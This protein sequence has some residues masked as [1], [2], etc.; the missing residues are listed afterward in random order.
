MCVKLMLPLFAGQ[1]ER[2]GVLQA[3]VAAA[4]LR[5]SPAPALRF[6]T[7]VDQTSKLPLTPSLVQASRANPHSYW[8]DGGGCVCGGRLM[9]RR[10]HRVKH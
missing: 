3:P 1:Q 10:W 6:W 9:Q 7:D 8:I 2:E 4:H 5:L